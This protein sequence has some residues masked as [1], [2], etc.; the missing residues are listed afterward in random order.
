MADLSITA[1]NV[2]RT[3]GQQKQAT[4]GEAITAGQALYVSA[5]TAKMLRCDA[6]TAAKAAC[7]GIALHAAA[8]DQP[9]A[10]LANGDIDLGATLA[11]GTVY[12]VTDTAG[13]IGPIADRGTG[14]F[15]TLLGVASA[16]DNLILS[17]NRTGVAIA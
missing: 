1:A 7:D 9:I 10:Y 17:I 11:V 15:V 14:D 5:T 4:A 3:S 6:S 8:A 16:A 13:G 12:G 2:Q